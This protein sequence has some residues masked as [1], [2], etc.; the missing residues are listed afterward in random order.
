M[1]N[2]GVRGLAD[3]DAILAGVKGPPAARG[4]GGVLGGDGESPRVAASI[5]SVATPKDTQGSL[6]GRSK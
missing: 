6:V 2:E 1:G 5:F 4:V 3:Q